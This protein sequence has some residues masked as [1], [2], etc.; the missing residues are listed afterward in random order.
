MTCRTL[1]PTIFSHRPT[2]PSHR[3]ILFFL[4]SFLPRKR[5]TKTCALPSP[6]LMDERPSSRPPNKKGWFDWQFEHYDREMLVGFELSNRSSSIA[7]LLQ[8]CDL[9]PPLKL[10]SPIEDDDKKKNKINTI[11]SAPLLV[12]QNLLP[13]PAPR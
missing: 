13:R 8:N 5:Q 3:P 2:K 12:P 11:D 7:N 9:P 6:R 1:F 4:L 10:F